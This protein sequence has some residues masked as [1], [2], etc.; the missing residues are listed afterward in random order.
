MTMQ[1]EG[2]IGRL[3]INLGVQVYIAA[4]YLLMIAQ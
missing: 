2:D 3:D 1:M 4:N